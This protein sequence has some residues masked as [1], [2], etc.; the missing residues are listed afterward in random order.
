MY[1]RLTNYHCYYL[2]GIVKPFNQSGTVG[3][4]SPMGRECIGTIGGYI[5]QPIKRILLAW[6]EVYIVL[7]SYLQSVIIFDSYAL[8]VFF[9]LQK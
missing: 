2:P 1:T 9:S 7:D 6:S 3:D 5:S 8:S 4:F